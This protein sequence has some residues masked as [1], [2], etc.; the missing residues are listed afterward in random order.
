LHLGACLTH[1]LL[2]L[3]ACLTHQLLHLGAC[4]THQLHEARLIIVPAVCKQTGDYATAYLCY[5]S[6]EAAGWK[7]KARSVARTWSVQ[8]EQVL[9]L[10][11]D[12]EGPVN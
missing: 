12:D 6:R 9:R 2:H 7:Q 8:P 5:K 3:G 1:Q 10:E 11:P 4:L